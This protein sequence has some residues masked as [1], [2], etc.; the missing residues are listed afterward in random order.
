MALSSWRRR[1]KRARSRPCSR[2][3]GVDLRVDTCRP[4]GHCP[5]TS[6]KRCPNPS[7]FAGE[8]VSAAARSEIDRELRS[9]IREIPNFPK[10]G[11]DFKDIT[12][13]LAN[14]GAFRK[15]T[16]AMAEPFGGDSISHVIGIESRGFILGAPIEKQLGA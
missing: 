15:A 8:N 10:P 13:L 3:Y 11:I 2:R 9:F 4:G 1:A 16:E 6:T 5:W 12:P 14:A 7:S